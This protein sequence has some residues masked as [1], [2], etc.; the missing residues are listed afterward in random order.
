MDDLGIPSIYG[1]LQICAKLHQLFFAHSPKRALTG[2]ISAEAGLRC[3]G[4]QGTAT[5]RWSSCCW[6]LAPL[7]TRRADSATAPELGKVLWWDTRAP[8]LHWGCTHVLFQL[9]CVVQFAKNFAVFGSVAMCCNDA[10]GSTCLFMVCVSWPHLLGNRCEFAC[11]GTGVPQSVLHPFSQPI[12]AWA[13]ACDPCLA[14]H[15]RRG[16]C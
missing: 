1:N 4:Q 16:F 8:R 13:W 5:P 15:L 12:Q 14:Y 6:R 2:S 9:S 11:W 10:Q 3:S 7:C